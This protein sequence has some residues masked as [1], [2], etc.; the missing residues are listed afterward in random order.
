M[1]RF[2]DGGGG[3]AGLSFLCFIPVEVVYTLYSFI[4]H[5]SE[6][7]IPKNF[8]KY[9]TVW[10]GELYILWWRLQNDYYSRWVRK[11][12]EDEMIT[13]VFH[14]CHISIFIS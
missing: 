5:K 10:F 9:I 1:V 11:E 3:C 13:L 4:I 8:N 6:F 7:C 2:G 12:K 14:Y